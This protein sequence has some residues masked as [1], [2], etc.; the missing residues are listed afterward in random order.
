M[1]VLTGLIWVFRAAQKG[2]EDL[3]RT[4]IPK[5]VFLFPLEMRAQ[6][7]AEFAQSGQK[8]EHKCHRSNLFSQRALSR[9]SQGASRRKVNALQLVP[10]L[11]RWALRLWTVMLSPAQQSAQ[12]QARCAT[13]RASADHNSQISQSEFQS[14]RGLCLR[15]DF[16][17]LPASAPRCAGIF[18]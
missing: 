17:F 18:C 7:R 15:G 13:T 16:T 11:A 8:G 4:A 14:P 3:E 2:I 6:A 5:N 10:V 12:P 9:F 1:I